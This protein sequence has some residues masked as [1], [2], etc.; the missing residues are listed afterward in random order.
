MTDFFRLLMYHMGGIGICSE[1]ERVCMMLGYTPGQPSVLAASCSERVRTWRSFLGLR[2]TDPC[3]Y[4][5][6]QFQG[7]AELATASMWRANW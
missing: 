3:S 6:D 7:S 1:R 2:E 5:D 4:N